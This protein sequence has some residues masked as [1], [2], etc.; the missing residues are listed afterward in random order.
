MKR[1]A[2]GIVPWLVA[3]AILA[4]CERG[5]GDPSAPRV[6]PSSEASPAASP[7]PDQT[8][9]G[10]PGRDRSLRFAVI[11]DFGDRSLEQLTVAARMCDWRKK[12]PFDLVITTG[13]NVYPDGSSEWF[14]ASF[15]APYKCLLDD[16]V[17]WHASLGNHDWMTDEGRAELEEPAFGMDGENYV[18]REAGVRFVIANSNDMDIEWLEQNL[19]ARSGDRWTVAVFHHPVFSPGMHG[20]TESFGDLPELFARAGV[21]LVLNGHDHLYSVTEPQ[22][23]IRYVVTGGGGAQLYPCLLSEESE[24]CRIEHHFLS[25]RADEDDI[26]VRAVP[27]RGRPFDRFTTRG[28]D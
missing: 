22:Q 9:P 18:V 7:S 1:S 6:A 23:G 24:I 11:G 20:S 13:D 3:L 16:G 12:H 27:D 2:I 17:R 21:D 4:A 19:P 5:S 15:F 14:D 25:V 10:G 28:I 26:S 8:P